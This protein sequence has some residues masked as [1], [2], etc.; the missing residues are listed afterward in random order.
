M[1]MTRR[2]AALSLWVL[3]SAFLAGCESRAGQVDVEGNRVPIAATPTALAT[4]QPQA[5]PAPSSNQS[6]PATDTAAPQPSPSPPRP[7]LQPPKG[8]HR[9]G[10]TGEVTAGGRVVSAAGKAFSVQVVDAPLGSATVKVALAKDR[11]GCTEPLEAMALAH[12][13]V[14]AI[15]GCFFDAY[16]DRPVR[17]P[18][19]NVMVHGEVVHLSDHPTTLGVWPDGLVAI[20]QVRFGVSGG[21]DGSEHYPDNWYAYGINDFPE[22]RNWVEVYTSQHGSPRSPD[23][24]RYVVVRAGEIVSVGD[25]PAPI[26][27]DGYVLHLRGQETYLCSRLTPGRK[28]AY[29]VTVKSADPPL[30]W[31]SA[32]EALGCGPLL[33]REGKVTVNPAAEGFHDEKVLSGCCGRS[34]VGWTGSGHLLLVT[35]PAATMRDL[36]EVMWALGCKEAMNLDGGASSGL[37]FRGGYVTRPGRDV[38]NALVVQAAP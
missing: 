28:C 12:R 32:Q 33:V 36:G 17:N 9:R 23:G 22:G 26:P 18:Y 30:D 14:A 38:S 15:N 31:L 19:G 3:A 27:R 6:A 4:E 34:A 1:K 16:S 8:E 24:G 35:C 10:A 13:G 21:L 25:G 20:G 2:T 11:V 5:A 7:S 37:W 29:H